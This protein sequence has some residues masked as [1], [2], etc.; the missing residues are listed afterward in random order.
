MRSRAGFTIT[1][2]LLV[3][4]LVGILATAGVPRAARAFEEGRVDEATSELL[5][6]WRGQRLHWLEQRS[7]ADDLRDLEALDLVGPEVLKASGPFVF[8]IDSASDSGF[9]ASATRQQSAEWSGV[10]TIDETGVLAGSLTNGAGDE[11]L[12]ADV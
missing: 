11:I 2:L 7:F 1:E 6:I 3:A 8:A 5:S 9:S 10:L 4:A 12:L